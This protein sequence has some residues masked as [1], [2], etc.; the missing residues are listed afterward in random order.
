MGLISC[1]GVV[2]REVKVGDYD[3]ILTVISPKYGKI[4]VSGKGVRSIKNKNSA[5][6]GLLSY[7]SFEL[8][9]GREIHS[10]VSCDLKENFYALR[11]D[12]YRLSMGCYFGELASFVA[13]ENEPCEALV[14]LLLNTLFFLQK[15]ESSQDAL[16]AI[17]E[18]RLLVEE[19]LSPSADSCVF[20]GSA[21]NLRWFDTTEGCAVCDACREVDC[22]PAGDEVCR[23]MDRII[24]GTLKEAL[25][26]PIPQ[27][28]LHHLGLLS[29]KMITTHIAPSLRSLEYLK[30]LQQ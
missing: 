26:T 9:E 17:F 21:E 29:E 18:L 8:K 19:G 24:K 23:A 16:K 13:R 28:A 22:L 4:K 15:E 7:S 10:I 2:A 1:D 3:K 20:C 14:K 11:N 5:G 12:L 30:S 27:S 25:T 6:T